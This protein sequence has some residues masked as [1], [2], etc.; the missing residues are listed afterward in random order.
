MVSRQYTGIYTVY[1]TSG[2]LTPHVCAPHPS[3]DTERSRYLHAS[4]APCA[5]SPC[6]RGWH[7]PVATHRHNIHCHTDEECSKK[8]CS[9]N[10]GDNSRPGYSSE[11]A[12]TEPEEVGEEERQDQ[13]SED[14]SDDYGE[15]EDEDWD[16]WKKNEKEEKEEDWNR[17]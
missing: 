10:G 17:K 4:E 7:G 9:L 2:C 12:I 6:P 13:P 1:Y 8:L 3:E 15:N 16:E 11:S 5:S 14:E